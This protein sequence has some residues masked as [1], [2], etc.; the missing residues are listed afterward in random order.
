MNIGEMQRKLSLWATQ[1][2]E[3]KFYDL[4]DLMLTKDWIRLAHDHVAQ[5]A[6]SVTAGCDGIDMEIFD[7]KLEENLQQLIQDLKSKTFEP[8]P[9]RR[10][11]IP[12]ANGKVRPLGIPAIRDRIVQEAARMILEPIFEADFSR[13]SF[14]FRPNR[15]TMD[16]VRYIQWSMSERKKFFWIIEGDISSYFDTIHHPK[17]LRLLGRR[18][19]DKK[20][21]RLIWKFLR[22]GVMEKRTFK[23][24]KLGTPQGGVISPLLANIYLHELDRSMERY[25]ALT[26]TEKAKRRRNR[27]GNFTYA[28]YADDFVVL[29]NGG[30]EQAEKMRE[31]LY[32]FLGQTL[33]LELSKEK[34]KISHANDG[35]TFLG[36]FIRRELGNRGVMTVK[37]TIPNTAMKRLQ[38]NLKQSLARDQDSVVGKIRGI[39][40][41]LRGWCQYYQYTSQAGVQFHEL[42]HF[43]FWEMAH[44]IGRKFK[45]HMPAIMQKYVIDNTFVYEGNRLIMA[46][47]FKAKSYHQTF[48]KP[49]PYLMVERKLE[50]EELPQEDQWVA[51]ESRPGRA[52]LRLQTLT[53]DNYTCRGCGKAVTA[54]TADVDHIRPVRRFKRP[55]DADTLGNL[56]TLCIPCHAAKTKTDHYAE[57]RMR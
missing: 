9:V 13:Y 44:W 22:A 14:G 41:I 12:K 56:Q 51:Y 19:E 54:E 46:K 6:G 1:D 38:S 40:R 16:A 5:N 29:C 15:R 31:E 48:L 55:V 35:F 39:N 37:V 17:L 33:R 26:Q 47:E 21:L 43:L 45:I 53:R 18:I 8:Q 4:Y 23:D 52:D 10:V 25:T 24:T 27:A 2:K 50:R 42:D 32:T 7:K 20:M 34:T 36:F 57:S 28:R 49:N 3:R 30:K 11:Y